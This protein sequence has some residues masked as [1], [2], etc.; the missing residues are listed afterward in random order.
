MSFVHLHVHSEYSLLDG[1]P[2]IA[3]LIKRAKELKMPAIALTDHGAM[4]GAVK[5]YNAALESGVKPIIGVEAY[6]AQRSRFDKE[7]GIDKELRHQLLLAKNETG[8]KN[9]MKLVTLANLEGYYYKPRID[10][11]LLKAFHEGIIATS[12]CLQGEIPRLIVNNRIDEAKAALKWYLEVFGEDYYLELQKHIN[13]P[14]LEMVN[15]QLMKMSREFGVPLVATNDVHYINEDDAEAQD[16]L[17]A[18]GTK[19]LLSDKDR[20]SM[21][22]S[23]DFYLKSAEEMAKLFPDIPEALE[24]TLKIADKCQL[25]LHIG[26]WS[27]PK[28]PFEEGETP[29]MGLAR[30]TEEGLKLRFG[31]ISDQ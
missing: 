2:K 12:S 30:L 24:N 1:L 28:Y 7:V 10:R 27:L 23:P 15:S 6:M 11:E 4:Y 14:E 9:L 29:E 31:K 22:S 21:I 19:K 26:K 5:F 3:K 25:T 17:L 8:Y 13:V 20:L 16:A 18:V